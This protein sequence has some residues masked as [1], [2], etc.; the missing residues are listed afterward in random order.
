M[1]QLTEQYPI[2]LTQDVLWGDMD[3]FGHVNN[4]VYFRY[5]EDARMAYFDRAGIWSFKHSENIGPILATTHCDFKL[6]LAYPDKIYI[7]TRSEILSAKKIKMQYRVYSEAFNAIAAEGEGLLVYYDYNQAK[8][9]EIP[10]Q[11]VTA[12]E[13]LE[14]SIVQR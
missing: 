10:T 8:S 3:A 2:V 5:F 9:T 13:L 6:P 14:Q 1:K 4:T 12:I 7:A 11:I